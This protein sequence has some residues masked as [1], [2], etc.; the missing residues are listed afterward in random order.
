MKEII[1]VSLML[2][3][4]LLGSFGALYLKK[5]S[6]TVS[7]NIMQLLKNRFLIIG[8]L[9]YA[10]CTIIAIPAYENGPAKLFLIQL[11]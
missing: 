6:A 7:F 3:S 9:T 2:I 5:A 11:Q 4:A 8:V 1:G 10:F